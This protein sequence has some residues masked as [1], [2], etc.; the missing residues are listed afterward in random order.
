MENREQIHNSWLPSSLGP[1]CWFTFGGFVHSVP[2]ARNAI[3]SSSRAPIHLL[4]LIQ[5]PPHLEV[6]SELLMNCIAMLNLFVYFPTT[7]RT[8]PLKEQNARLW[9]EWTNSVTPCTR[10]P[11]LTPSPE[12]PEG[13]GRRKT[14]FVTP[15]PKVFIMIV[16]M[17]QAL[18]YTRH[19]YEYYLYH[20]VIES[21]QQYYKVP[22]V[23]HY[24]SKVYRGLV[25]YSR[26]RT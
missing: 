23:R 26:S 15:F 1:S 12:G 24:D 6:I 14:S 9:A 8:T 11:D 16:N 13:H 3:I 4:R 10:R 20:L 7:L 17:S 2:S 5:I 21:S 25:T 19:N 22:C 18:T